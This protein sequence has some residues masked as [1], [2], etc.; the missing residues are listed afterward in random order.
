MFLGEDLIKNDLDRFRCMVDL[1]YKEKYEE[2]Q[3][4]KEIARKRKEEIE[5]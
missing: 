4:Q 2:D 1:E 3:R 5:L